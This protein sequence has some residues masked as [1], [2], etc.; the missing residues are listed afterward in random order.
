M[1]RGEL[2]ETLLRCSDVDTMED[3]VRSWK[4]ER[5]AAPLSRKLVS[6]IEALL[7]RGEFAEAAAVSLSLAYEHQDAFISL[8]RQSG[9]FRASR[10]R[11][12]TSNLFEL[13]QCLR[14]LAS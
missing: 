4:G 6:P 9:V 11:F 13:V 14:R 3:V 7:T 8:A 12:R 10:Y 5:V 1:D 2:K